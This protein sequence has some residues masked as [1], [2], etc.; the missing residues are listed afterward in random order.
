MLVLGFL[1]EDSGIYQSWWTWPRFLLL[2]LLL[3]FGLVVALFY[4]LIELLLEERVVIPENSRNRTSARES[5]YHS[6]VNEH[7]IC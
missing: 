5:D 3:S 6:D 2:S 7:F 1:D 4:S